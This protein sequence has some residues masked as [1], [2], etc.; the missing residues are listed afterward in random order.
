MNA[1]MD[2]SAVYFDLASQD[3]AVV[4]QIRDEGIGISPKDEQRLFE[5][6]HRGQNVGNIPGT[7]LGLAIVKK[8]VEVHGG[9]IAVTSVVGVGTTFTVKFPLNHYLQR[10]GSL[11]NAG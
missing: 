7:G 3:G 8:C 1:C 4:F 5:S 9:Q 10:R 11:T 2:K 6:F